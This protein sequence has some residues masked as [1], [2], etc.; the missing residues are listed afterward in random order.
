M[1]TKRYRIRYALCSN[2]VFSVIALVLMAMVPTNIGA[3]GYGTDTIQEIKNDGN[4]DG[5]DTGVSPND[6]DNTF[7]SLAVHPTDPNTVIFGNEGNGFFRSTDGGINWSRPNTGLYYSVGFEGGSCFYPEIY[8]IIFDS[9]DPAKLY[10]AT[11]SG[12]GA[13]STSVTQIAGVYYSLDGGNTW[14]QSVRGLHNYAVT[15]I[16]QDPS[17]SN[18]LYIGLDNAPPTSTSVT[19]TTDGPNI[20]KSTDSGLNWSGL[21]LPVDDNRIHNILVDSSNSD[22]IYCSGFHSSYSGDMDSRHLG[23]AKS[24]DGGATWNRINNSLDSLREPFISLDPNNPSTLYASVWT[25]EG[26]KAYKSTDRGENWT[27]FSGP[28]PADNLAKLKVS[29]FDSNRLTGYCSDGVCS[30]TDGGSSWALA[31][32]LRGSGLIFNDIE[33][34]S[35]PDIVYASADHLEIF[36]SVNGGATFFTPEVTFMPAVTTNSATSVS[37]DSAILNGTIDPN[38]KTT[39]Y[40]FEY[41]VDTSYGSTTASANAGSGNSAIS[42]NASISGLIPDTT[43]NYRLVATNSDGT[44]YGDNKTFSTTILYVDP[45]GSCNDNTPCYTTIQSAIDAAS[46]GSVIKILAGTYAEN[47]DLKS[48]NNYELQGG[49]NAAYSSQTSTSS[50]SFMTFGSSS[51]TVTVGGMVVQ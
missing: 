9:N 2:C 36:K 45:S 15:A 47:L 34:T 21:T 41:G 44:S 8:Q 35:D 43:Y 39:N 29:P 40:Y 25:D 46:S 28:G 48:S 50:V 26:A 12:P 18:V 19:E 10:A 6:S 13:S 14:T 30:T 42:V 32:D 23:F 3:N 37:S 27:L 33:F 16:A 17:N 24:I 22:I 49:W 38:G 11:T 7:R 1:G 4:C 20:Y 5:P 31:L 51:G